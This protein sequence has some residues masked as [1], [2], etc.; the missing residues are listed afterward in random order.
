VKKREALVEAMDCIERHVND[1][2]REDARRR[3]MVSAWIVLFKLAYEREPTREQMNA[4]C[5]PTWW[6]KEGS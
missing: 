1:D 5:I 2:P 3:R 4:H 6:L